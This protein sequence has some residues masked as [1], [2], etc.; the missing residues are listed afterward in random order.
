MDTDKTAR[1]Y[2][3]NWRTDLEKMQA[4]QDRI[5][6]LLEQDAAKDDFMIMLESRIAELE[7]QLARPL[8]MTP[9]QLAKEISQGHNYSI[10]HPPT[11]AVPE[12]ADEI[13]IE[14][15]VFALESGLRH[16]GE[17]RVQIV[18]NIWEDMLA[19]APDSATSA[20]AEG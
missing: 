5:A 16:F 14:V 9:R 13:M 7:S 6:E 1:D 20:G 2:L 17:N 10:G 8:S 3:E 11:S 15:G 4:M 18:S 19:A 12:V